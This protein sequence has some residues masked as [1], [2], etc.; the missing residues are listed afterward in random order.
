VLGN[1]ELAEVGI[2]DKG[3]LQDSRLEVLVAYRPLLEDTEQTAL[4]FL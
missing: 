2:P 3:Y 4:R 1:K